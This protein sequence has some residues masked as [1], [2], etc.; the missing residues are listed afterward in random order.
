MRRVSIIVIVL[1]L[2]MLMLASTSAMQISKYDID[3]KSTENGFSIYENII[4]VLDSNESSLN[5]SIQDDATDIVISIN[6]QSVEYNKSGNMY[7]CAIPPTNESSVSASITY[8]LPKSTKFFEKHILYPSSEVTI[9]Y[10]GSTL[11]SRSDLGENSYISAS[12][13]V[14]TVET[15]GYA[16]YAIAAL[17][18][19]LIV[20]IIAYLAKKRTSKPV[21][22]E[23][24]EILKTKKALLMMLL[25][26]IEK[27]HRAEEISDESYRYLKD[28]Y[29]REAVEVMKKLES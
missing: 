14:K 24:E 21:Q 9:T 6:G 17:L 7:T 20:I 29:K 5:F 11:L 28:L 26:E 1:S 12:L 10:D 25:K 4:G 23:T 8:Y 16:L 13:V 18:L 19:A 22:M 27:K 3:V 15:T 2:S